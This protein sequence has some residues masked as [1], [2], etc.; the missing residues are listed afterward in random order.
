MVFQ[1]EAMVNLQSTLVCKSRTASAENFFDLFFS[2]S[3]MLD[4][5]AVDSWIEL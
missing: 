4:L 2:T 1:Q 3:L 5:V